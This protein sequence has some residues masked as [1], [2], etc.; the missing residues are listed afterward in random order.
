LVHELKLKF[1]TPPGKPSRQ[2]IL[3][4]DRSTI[5]LFFDK[6]AWK[7]YMK[8][9]ILPLMRLGVVGERGHVSIEWRCG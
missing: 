6:L 8:I 9:I 1:N 2:N 4:E 5:F 3:E 7:D